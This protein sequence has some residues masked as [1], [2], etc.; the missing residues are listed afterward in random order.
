[1]AILR[2]LEIVLRYTAQLQGEFHAGIECCG[3]ANLFPA[4]GTNRCCLL[5]VRSLSREHLGWVLSVRLG[6]VS[7]FWFVLVTRCPHA[8]GRASKSVLQKTAND[9][10]LRI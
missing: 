9:N 5:Y 2:Q 3:A 6:G 7:L 8:K 10:L 4:L 1:M